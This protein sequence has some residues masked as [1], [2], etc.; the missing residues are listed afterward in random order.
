MF[1][2][3][4]LR[5]AG[6][7]ARAL[8]QLD[9]ALP[10][11]ERQRGGDTAFVQRA[12]M[13]RGMALVDLD[14]DAEALAPLHSAHEYGQKH[15]FEKRQDSVAGYYLLALSGLGRCVDALPLAEEIAR[16]HLDVAS[17]AAKAGA[18]KCPRAWR[19]AL[20]EPQGF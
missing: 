11:L 12:L 20:R 13:E 3:N 4:T 15:A 9:Q 8:A 2:A 6:Q 18:A 7:A 10:G 17:Q 1:F 16:R 19:I 5:R 14:R